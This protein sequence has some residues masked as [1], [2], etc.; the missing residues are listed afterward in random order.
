MV[1]GVPP[2]PVQLSPCVSELL[3]VRR[4]I[5]L[6]RL[7][8]LLPAPGQ[9]ALDGVQVGDLGRRQLGRLVMRS[10][11]F[12]GE[13]T[14]LML[15]RRGGR[16]LGIAGLRHHGLRRRLLRGQ[17]LRLLRRLMLVRLIRLELMERLGHGRIDSVLETRRRLRWLR[18]E[19]LRL[20]G[21]VLHS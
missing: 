4:R 11:A 13:V 3:V 2:A 15:L 5:R 20:D 7:L 9:Q 16:R 6:H 14:P 18:G 12:L 21:R 17:W 19:V 10:P 8:A 1:G